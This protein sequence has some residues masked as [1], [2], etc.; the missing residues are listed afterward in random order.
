M[1]RGTF[2]CFPQIELWLYVVTMGKLV[3]AEVW[4]RH[5]FMNWCCSFLLVVSSNS[6]SSCFLICFW[7]LLLLGLNHVSF[8]YWS[9]MLQDGKVAISHLHPSV[10]TMCLKILSEAFWPWTIH[11]S[12]VMLY[13]VWG[14]FNTH[15]ALGIAQ[16]L[17]DFMLT[18]FNPSLQ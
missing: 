14:M 9:S 2:Q 17:L 12:A 10:H 6:R 8:Q 16:F 13:N 7:E 4:Y 15:C 3:I 11:Y 5:C 1:F 18:Y